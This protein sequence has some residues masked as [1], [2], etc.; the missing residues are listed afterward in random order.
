[1]IAISPP[2][3]SGELDLL[4]A[5]NGCHSPYWDAAMWAISHFA[6]WVFPSIALFFFLFWRRPKSEAV[7]L[8]LCIGLCVAIGDVLSSHIAK[9]FFERLRPTHTPEL[10][11]SLHYVY[12]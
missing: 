8:L 6:A 7:L 9:P 3:I 5:I 12:V 2:F 10:Q 4:R 11:D 1:M